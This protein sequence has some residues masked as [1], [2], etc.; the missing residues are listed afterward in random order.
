MGGSAVGGDVYGAYPES[1][2]LGN[3]L[4]VGRGRLVPTTS[5]DEYNAELV[6]RF[7][8]PNDNNLEIILPNIRNFYAA[9]DSSLP[10][11]FLG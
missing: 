8:V 9:G 7:G 3:P 1:L 5:V 11:G 10:L 2:G 4:E 6:R